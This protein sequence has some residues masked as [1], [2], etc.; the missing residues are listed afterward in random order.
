MDQRPIPINIYPNSP[1]ALSMLSQPYTVLFSC[2][3][4]ALRLPLSPACQDLCSFSPVGLGTI[5]SGAGELPSVRLPWV[6]VALHGVSGLEVSLGHTIS[7]SE[8]SQVI[9]AF[10]IHP[11]PY[12]LPLRQSSRACSTQA[13]LRLRDRHSQGYT[14]TVHFCL[15][16]K[17][18]RTKRGEPALQTWEIIL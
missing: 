10:R 18:G 5:K 12:R 14:G 3:S 9:Q 17:E 7:H 15:H 4:S 11:K 8:E 13:A 1:R 16:R 2:C 6:C